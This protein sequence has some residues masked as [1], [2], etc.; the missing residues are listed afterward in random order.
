MATTASASLPR[1]ASRLDAHLRLA[2]TLA[3]INGYGML[4]AAAIYPPIWG[5]PLLVALVIGYITFFRP[6]PILFPTSW[7]TFLTFVLVMGGFVLTFTRQLF[8]LDALNFILLLLPLIKY[9]TAKTPRDY[10][11]VLA[12][13][14]SQII[15]GTVVNFELSFGLFLASY[16]FLAMWTL[17]LLSFRARILD[18]PQY[19]VLLQKT[20]KAIL[21]PRFAAFLLISIPILVLL[22][23]LGFFVLPR[24]GTALASFSFGIQKRFSGFSNEVNI[25]EMGEIKLNHAVVLRVKTEGP[26]PPRPY[27]WRG[28]VMD[29]FEG[30]R[31]RAKRMDSIRIAPN[32]RRHTFAIS[33]LPPE[34]MF[35]QTMY[36]D[37]LEA[38]YLLHADFVGRV[39]ANVHM[40]T[41]RANDAV[42][43]PRHARNL[44]RYTVWSQPTSPLLL[45]AQEMAAF[46]QLPGNLDPRIPELARRVAGN[47]QTP[48]QIAQRIEAHLRNDYSYSLNPDRLPSSDPLAQFLFETR[49]GHCEYFASAMTV[50]LRTQGIHSRLVTGFQEGEYNDNEDYFIVRQSDAHA[51][52]EARIDD[53]W[54]RFDPTPAAGWET[55][56]QDIWS[57]FSRFADSLAFRWQRYVIAFTVRDQV[58]FL[59]S[60][61]ISIHQTSSESIKRWFS[62]HKELLAS[63]L[64]LV[65]LPLLWLNRGDLLQRFKNSKQKSS[66]EAALSKRFQTLAK[67]LKKKGLPH[68][69]GQTAGEWLSLAQ[70]RFPQS[71]SLLQQWRL[72]FEP[73]RYG[74][75]STNDERLKQLDELQQ[76]I[77]QRLKQKHPLQDKKDR[78]ANVE[79]P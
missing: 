17:M 23:F 47:A 43:F 66:Q 1:P 39:Q 62:E 13:A 74:R 50:M 19:P 10:L 29:T 15:Y 44:Q 41:L 63:L 18:R 76:A 78:R 60:S 5:L 65:L 45:D 33:N 69:P 55:Y 77:A 16:L 14:F 51:W 70:H 27:Y 34:R 11:Q 53:K 72:C 22:T 38:R 58:A 3:V 26:S 6:A 8:F 20:E 21:R 28:A 36:L 31:W 40:L 61:E 57:R 79:L 2:L 64:L 35:K 67:L 24:P 52:V 30:M 48:L 7:W 4:F 71:A 49:S 37:D 73:L 46:L 56:A 12:L 25:G 9:F 59:N 75:I 42:T 68:A 54:Q 32:R